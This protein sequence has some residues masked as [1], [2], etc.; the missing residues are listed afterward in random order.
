MFD[1]CENL[2]ALN[3]R[4]TGLAARDVGGARTKRPDRGCQ[5]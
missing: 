4:G 2:A 5:P 3:L 1:A